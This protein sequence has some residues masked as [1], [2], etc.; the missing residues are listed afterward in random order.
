MVWLWQDANCMQTYH[1]QIL[2]TLLETNPRRETILHTRANDELVRLKELS[3]E[4]GCCLV[5]YCHFEV[6]QWME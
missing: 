4:L 3:A 2:E 6:L 1:V 5:Y